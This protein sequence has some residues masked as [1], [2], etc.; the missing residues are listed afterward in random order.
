MGNES[1]YVSL[2]LRRHIL[3]QSSEI[4]IQRG[5]SRWWWIQKEITFCGQNSNDIFAREK[6]RSATR[7]WRWSTHDFVDEHTFLKLNRV[8]SPMS[9]SAR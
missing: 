2:L 4:E 8:C 6:T 7:G 5:N 3:L 1:I 9:F